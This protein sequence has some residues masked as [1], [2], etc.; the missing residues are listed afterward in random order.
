M[1]RTTTYFVLLL[2][3]LLYSCESVFTRLAA[4]YEFLSWGYV[5]YVACAVAVLGLYAILWQQI[6]K[7]MP[8]SDAYMFK[9]LTIVFVLI[10]AS[11]LFGEK[12]TACNCIGAAIIIGGI[13][14]YAKT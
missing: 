7:R 4:G 2:A 11:L 3:Y 1:T 8:I 6:I 14:L 10:L 13:C 9:G 12:I 5:G